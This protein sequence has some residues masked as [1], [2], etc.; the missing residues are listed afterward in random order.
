MI[1]NA[2]LGLLSFLPV[3]V[4]RHQMEMGL[5]LVKLRTA[6]RNLL[7][8]VQKACHFQC[9]ALRNVSLKG[10]VCKLMF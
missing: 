10:G 3:T 9:K 2:H 7:I 6:A 1:Q 8:A 5:L 4:N